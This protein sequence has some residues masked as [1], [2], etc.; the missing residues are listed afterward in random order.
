MLLNIKVN[1]PSNEAHINNL[2][3]VKALLIK[4]TIDNMKIS[5]NER[6]RI[7]NEILEYLENN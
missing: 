4:K 3:Y 7:L 5:S 2:A 6:E 1:L